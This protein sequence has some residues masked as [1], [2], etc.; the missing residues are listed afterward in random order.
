[1]TYQDLRLSSVASEA[2]LNSL[3][4]SCGVR[5]H[6][7][8]CEEA[9]LIY[10]TY[11]KDCDHAPLTDRHGPAH[12]LKVR[13]KLDGL[14]AHFRSIDPAVVNLTYSHCQDCISASMHFLLHIAGL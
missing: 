2:I 8:S 12:Q 6:M 1:M 11:I 7:G 4:M 13:S 9:I 14:V 3:P 5:G 10:C